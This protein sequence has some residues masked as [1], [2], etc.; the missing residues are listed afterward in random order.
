MKETF[1]K[2]LKEK[3]LLDKQFIE[4]YIKDY[5]WKN[6]LDDELQCIQIENKAF[7]LKLTN[8]EFK[9][10]Y[11]YY[12]YDYRTMFLYLNDIYSDLINRLNINEVSYENILKLNMAIL[13]IINHELIH[14]KQ[15]SIMN[16]SLNYVLKKTLTESYEHASNNYDNYLKNHDKYIHEYNAN[17]LSQIEV[18]NFLANPDFNF[19]YSS[20]IK[21]YLN[22]YLKGDIPINNFY[23]MIKC[24]LPKFVELRGFNNLS[25][26]DKLM[27]GFDVDEKT[28]ERIKT[29]EKAK[30][31]KEYFERR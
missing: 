17:I 19:I 6:S 25:N 15:F 16:N 10:D 24:E 28:K 5:I 27:Y 13:T 14:A 2:Y 11:A 20:V 31:Y 3:E 1:N 23:K 29:L 7:N 8:I 12:C 4:K 22:G 18:Y 21:D 26:F 9:E 30:D